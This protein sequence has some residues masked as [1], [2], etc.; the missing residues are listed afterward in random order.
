MKLCK[1][2]PKEHLWLLQESFLRLFNKRISIRNI[3]EERERG[4]RERG[5]PVQPWLSAGSCRKADGM[6]GGS[7]REAGT[8]P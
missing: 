7:A 4:G 2:V 3:R 1:M 8:K 6:G 5:I